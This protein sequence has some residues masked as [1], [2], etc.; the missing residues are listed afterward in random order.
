MMVSDVESDFPKW[1][2]V[3]GIVTPIRI[4]KPPSSGRRDFIIIR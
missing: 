3:K 2:L 4:L 1:R